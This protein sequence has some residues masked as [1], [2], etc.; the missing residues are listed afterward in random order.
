MTD[1]AGVL[2]LQG[3]SFPCVF[4]QHLAQGVQFY[5]LGYEQG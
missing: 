3:P 2:F 5:D 4:L 1:K